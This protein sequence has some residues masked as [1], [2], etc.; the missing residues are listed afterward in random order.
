MYLSAEI[1]SLS[2]GVYYRRSSEDQN[3]QVA[4]LHQQNESIRSLIKKE[5]LESKVKNYFQES[6]SAKQPGRPEFNRLMNDIESGTINGII[7][8]DLSRLS[9]NP[10]D[11]GK[12]F[13]MLQQGMLKAIEDN[14]ITLIVELGQANQFLRDLSKNVKRGLH[15]KVQKGHRPGV[16]PEGYLNNTSEEKGCRGIIVD[17]DRFHLVRKMWELL[18]AGSYTVP[19]I[20][21]IANND[22]KYRTRSHRH[23]GNNPLSRSGLYRIFT[24]PFYYGEF[25]YGGKWYQG[26]HS[27][28]ITKEEFD[29]AQVI[30]GRKGKQRPK[31]RE[32]SYTGMI[33]CGECGGTITAEEKINRYGTRYTYYHCTKKKSPSCSQGS[34]ELGKLDKQIDELLENIEIPRSFETW[35]IQYLNVLHD[36][37]SIEQT[38]INKNID[39]QYSDCLARIQNL[40]K[41]KISPL[42]ID[43]SILS[44][45]DYKAQID[46][47]NK[48]KH[49]LEAQKKNLGERAEEWEELSVQTFNF[50]RYARYHFEKS[51]L[52]KKREIV[53][54][55]GSNFSLID[56]KIRLDQLKPFL[57]IKNSKN[58]AE[59][60]IDSLELD[61]NVELTPELADLYN[62]NSTL[63]RGWDSNPR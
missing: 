28:M 34:V 8:W 49:D 22:W 51:S 42:N 37:E 41:L 24:N 31:T 32:F 33:H 26:S 19:Q 9:R 25:E 10:I 53:A 30:L 54:S 58:V 2:F 17:P 44:D 27:P 56:K 13:W 59:E 23:S 48:E 21:D 6:K 61:K 50:A 36:Q 55:L 29:Q 5:Q 57:N 43:N 52:K 3:H 45:E 60:I 4:S 40:I 15:S 46:T 14:V 47:L 20:L 11:S 1:R 12:L 7:V 18:L 63:R 38:T 62:A 39:T 35:A 16:A